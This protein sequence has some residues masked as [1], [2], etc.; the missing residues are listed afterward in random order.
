[1]T[2]TTDLQIEFNGVNIADA[3]KKE[4]VVADFF[5]APDIRNSDRPRGQQDGLFPGIDYYAGRTLTAELEIWGDDLTDFYNKYSVVRNAL[6]KT[7]AEKILEFKVP[8]WPTNLISF[9]RVRKCSGP[10]INQQFDLHVGKV[11]VQW[12]STDPRLY[13]ATQQSSTTSFIGTQPGR[14]YNLT[15]NRS[16]GGIVSSNTIPAVNAG[17]YDAPWTAIINGP[18][19]NPSIENATLGKTISFVGSLAT[20]EQLYVSSPPYS[21][22]LLGGTSSRYSW[23][24]DSTQWFL[25]QP[26][27]NDIRFNGSS[28]GTPTLDFF[29]RSAW[30]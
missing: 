18:V 21:T 7:S 17:N 19:T 15:F 20:G 16:F 22:V 3:D 12:E 5:T 4:I 28:A 9:C 26:G 24:V 27:N 11:V 2:V 25:L 14:T 1:M 23:L 8:G 10:Q 13:Q 29:W 30:I 6:V